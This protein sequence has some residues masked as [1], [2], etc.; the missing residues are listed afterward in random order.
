[1][2]HLFHFLRYELLNVLICLCYLVHF[3]LAFESH[4]RPFILPF[5]VK[6]SQLTSHD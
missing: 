4:N 6:S 3:A 2:F 1:M 5:R